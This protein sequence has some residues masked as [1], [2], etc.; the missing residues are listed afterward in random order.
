M[1]ASMSA[2]YG[3]LYQLLAQ[4]ADAYAQAVEDQCAVWEGRIPA[5]QPL[6]LHSPPPKAPSVPQF[7]TRE[8]HF[9]KEKMLLAGMS[10]MVSSLAG[11][12][13][14]VPSIRANMGCGIFPS[15]FPGIL[16]MLFD[17]QRMPW[18]IEH[19][20]K[21]TIKKLR[22][23]DITLTDEFKLGLE[24]MAYQA[25]QLEGTGAYVF[26]LDL[27]DAV[28]I[29]HLV[30]GDPFFYDLYDDPEFI[31]HLLDLSCR[32]IEVGIPECLK[33]MPHSD[34]VITHY[35]ELAMPRSLGGIKFSED[36]S[37][38][39][40]PDHIDEFTL[41]SLKR[42][43]EF[44]G[45]GYVHFCGYNEQLLDKFLN[46]DLVHGMNF[47]NPEKYDMEQV[48]RKFA[49][50]GKVFYGSIPKKA[51]EDYQQYFTRLTAAATDAQGRCWLL[52]SMGAALEEAE[53]I[54]AA[55]KAVTRN[56]ANEQ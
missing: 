52:L 18:I 45:G 48:L 23:E 5:H 50:A 38:L 40:C 16:P 3:E 11:G 54:R 41:P 43:L 49:Q 13:Q 22:P 19:L 32:A 1:D 31:H 10:G 14:A 25:E 2:V 30:Y 39:I 42:L 21:E 53:K 35:N 44:T 56:G 46:M 28:D 17:D 20:D 51:D 4:K 27:Q 37:T 34:T 9:D 8:I 29:A 47:G 15:L 36:T 7:T 12:M 55:W 6:L 33:V 26:P 24:H